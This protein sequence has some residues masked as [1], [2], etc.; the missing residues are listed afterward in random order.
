MNLSNEIFHFINREI[1]SRLFPSATNHV[2]LNNTQRFWQKSSKQSPRWQHGA[3]PGGN[4]GGGLGGTGCTSGHQ[5]GGL[6][7][8]GK[9]KDGKLDS[10]EDDRGDPDVIPAQYG[11]N[12]DLLFPSFVSAVPGS[13]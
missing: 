10:A 8:D 9:G 12:D 11:K 13:K 7:V 1:H 4:S 2:P 3:G 5:H 6:G